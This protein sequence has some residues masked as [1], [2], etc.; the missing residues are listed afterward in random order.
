[1]IL[2]L[3]CFPVEDAMDYRDLEVTV[4][5]FDKKIRDFMKMYN[6]T[7]NAQGIFEA[8]HF[9]YS[10]PVDPLNRTLLREAYIHVS[11]K[12]LLMFLLN[13]F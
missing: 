5:N 10:P 9:M 3:K 4:E 1:M 7:V 6:Y 2:F 13:H 8:I 12:L 11:Q